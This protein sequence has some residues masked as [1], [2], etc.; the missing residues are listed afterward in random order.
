MYEQCERHEDQ[1]RAGSKCT[2]RAGRT[3]AIH[4]RLSA[5]VDQWSDAV[6]ASRRTR[7][8]QNT[9]LWHVKR[10]QYR[11][12][13]QYHGDKPE[14][15]DVYV[16]RSSALSAALSAGSVISITEKVARGAVNGVA[17]VRPPG[18]HAEES[19]AMGFCFYNNVAIAA[20]IAQEIY[21]IHKILIVDWDIHHGNATENQFLDDPNVMYI[22]LHRYEK[23]SFYPGSGDPKVVGTGRGAG[24]NINIG[25]PHGGVGESI[26]PP[27]PRD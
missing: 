11:A 14:S 10:V 25:W 23:G 1:K 6:T 20:K 15:S 2:L 27:L 22:S 4:A 21:G 5:R 24:Y 8:V 13:A 3:K 19:C 12:A 7:T 26:R 9:P 18:H 17:N 16:N